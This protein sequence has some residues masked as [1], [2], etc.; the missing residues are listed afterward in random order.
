MIYSR[1]LQTLQVYYP[2]LPRGGLGFLDVRM[3]SASFPLALYL[4]QG[5]FSA[6]ILQNRAECRSQC[7][8]LAPL[9]IA[10][11]SVQLQLE[12]L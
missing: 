5:V 12:T 9:W 11:F 4:T 6:T 10:T 1:I 3:V 2:S 7:H 8:L